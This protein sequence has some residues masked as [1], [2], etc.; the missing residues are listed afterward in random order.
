MSNRAQHLECRRTLGW[1][2]QSDENCHAV[3]AWIRHEL[4]RAYDAMLREPL[5]PVLLQFVSVA[6]DRPG[7]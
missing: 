4:S 5:P 2:G 1:I 7:Q 3:D 6:P